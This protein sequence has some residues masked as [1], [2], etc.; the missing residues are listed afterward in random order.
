M[1]VL[2][3]GVATDTSIIN[4]GAAATPD[5]LRGPA[6]GDTQREPSQPGPT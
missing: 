2:V 6:A 4:R 3:M 5:S 1:G